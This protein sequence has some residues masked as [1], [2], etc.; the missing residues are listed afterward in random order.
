MNFTNKQDAVFKRDKN[1]DGQF[2]YGVTS[3]HIYCKPSCP[4][5]RPN[6]EHI[7]YFASPVLAEQA[8]Y[9]PCQRCHPDKQTEDVIEAI[10]MRLHHEPKLSL[11][12]FH[13]SPFYLQRTFKKATGL[14]PKA[15]VK[16]QKLERLKQTLKHAPTITEAIYDAGFESNEFYQHDYLGMTPSSYRKGGMNQTIFYT[17][18]N[19]PLGRMLI[20][21]TER[22]V[23]AIRFGDDHVL[24][25]EIKKEFP[26]ATITENAKALESYIQT[27]TTYLEGEQTLEL[28][29]DI[30]GTAFQYRVWQVLKKIPYGQTRSYSQVAEAI[31]D[32]KAVRAVATACASNPIALAIPCHR[33]VRSS[34]ELSGYRWG[35]EK[36]QKLLEQERSNVGLFE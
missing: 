19:T 13:L 26:K 17:H 16:T 30:T 7:R 1:A 4:S 6:P 32:P 36:K 8:G 33:V 27:I 12:A 10:K 24:L 31:G 5:R 29:L 35:I 2:V 18:A 34:G 14:S 28:A 11:N 3:T 20:A 9:R 23:C 21:A 22:G 25:Q 15:Y